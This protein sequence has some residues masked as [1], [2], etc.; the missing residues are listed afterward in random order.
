VFLYGLTGLRWGTDAITVD[1]FLTT[2]LPGVDVTGVKWHGSTFDISVG[3]QST[4]VTLR[5]G[6]P[7]A[8]RDGAG[9][10]HRVSAS[11][12]M[13]IPTRHPAPTAQPSGCTG[14]ITSAAATSRC[15]D[16]QWGNIS[17]A[18]P[19]QLWDCNGSAAQS[20]TRPG[21][22]T[23]TAAGKCMD[24]RD[25]SNADATP[26]QI[27]SCNGSPSQQWTYDK[28][29]GELEAFGKC[30]ATLGDGTSN[31]TMLVIETCDSSTT[32]RWQLPA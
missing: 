24:V 2:Q 4:T 27:H 25:G 8:V 20:W 7:L 22:G 9:T 26:V 29:T 13:A 21:N 10:F 16:I 32:Q 19:L 28:D 3:Q 15:V 6:P 31:G 23:V 18:T 1:P 30:L 17:D 12:P 5:S 14:P 11:E